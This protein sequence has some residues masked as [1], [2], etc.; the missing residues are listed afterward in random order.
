MAMV[1]AVVSAGDTKEEREERKAKEAKTQSPPRKRGR[2]SS[3]QKG[4]GK[5]KRSTAGRRKGG[6]GGKKVASSSAKGGGGPRRGRSAADAGR[7]GPGSSSA[8]DEEEAEEAS[9]A[10][11]SDSSDDSS[12][13]SSAAPSAV[14]PASSS[15]GFSSS[16]TT[17][18]GSAAEARAAARVAEPPPAP[19][20]LNTRD[21]LIAAFNGLYRKHISPGTTN[22]DLSAFH[23][24]R[25][26]LFKRQLGFALS[27]P[28]AKLLL[29][30]DRARA[31][32]KGL[33]KEE[34]RI[35]REMLVA[36]LSGVL[37][38]GLAQKVFGVAGWAVGRS[39]RGTKEGADI[40]S[41]VREAKT[42]MKAGGAAG[43]QDES[44]GPHQLARQRNRMCK[45]TGRSMKEEREIALRYFSLPQFA[46][47]DIMSIFLQ[48]QFDTTGGD[49]TKQPPISRAHFY[50]I[51]PQSHRRKRTPETQLI[52]CEH[53]HK[54][55]HV[56]AEQVEEQGPPIRVK[57]KKL[58]KKRTLKA[59]DSSSVAAAPRAAEAEGGGEGGGGGGG[60]AA[61]EEGK[62]VEEK[63][64]GEEQKEGAEEAEERKDEAAE[65]QAGEDAVMMIP[66]PMVKRIIVEV[67]KTPF[68]P[69]SPPR[70]GS[71]KRKVPNEGVQAQADAQ[72]DVKAS[73][74]E[75]ESLV[76]P[77]KRGR[78]K[79]I[80]PPFRLTEEM[81]PHMPFANPPLL[82]HSLH[83]A[84]SSSAQL[85]PP[86]PPL[87]VAPMQPDVIA[88][89]RNTEPAKAGSS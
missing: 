72:A 49:P 48:Y 68:L 89:S 32:F 70:R 67:V 44:R 63:A 21:E 50:T 47:A 86:M 10:D 79:R 85:L 45:T 54:P 43:P 25:R 35:E 33:D 42:K 16:P 83:S 18:L 76:V 7:V 3:K 37:G 74:S 41:Y 14:P 78:P 81:L 30:L 88:P 22:L 82:H 77:K 58:S 4:K 5:R 27:Y 66:G 51:A 57:K 9:D 62:V 46:E 84:A 28:E 24:A 11:S 65:E 64:E 13:D 87:E 31:L 40:A 56:R 61:S 75:S 12:D 34:D 1:D 36:L 53:C 26:R 17:A 60:G 69:P 8:S 71:R 23:C 2:S 73:A 29:I 38:G 55:L 80:R 59:D 39:M 52:E 19:P 15:S 20:V 6:K